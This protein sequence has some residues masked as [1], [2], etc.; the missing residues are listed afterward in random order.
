MLGATQAAL[1][2]ARAPSALRTAMVSMPFVSTLRPSIQLGLLKGIGEQHGFAVDTFHLSLELAAQ[3]GL[4]TYETLCHH[5]G[6]MF[7]DWLFSVEAFG[8][9][10]PDLA[11]ELP[12]VF[13]RELGELERAALLQA[14]GFERLRREAVP[15]FLRSVSENIDWTRYDVIGFTSTFQQTVASAA[16]ARRIRAVHPGVKIVFGGANLDGDMGREVVRT[17]PVIDYG[18]SGEAD[19]TFPALLRAFAAGREPGPL[20]GLI[21]RR[22]G[23]VLSAPVGPPTT[24]M[25]ELPAPIYDEYFERAARLDL[26]PRGGARQVSLPIETSRGC[27][28]GAKSHCT[29]CG[30]NGATMQ[31]RSKSSARVRSE[32]ASLSRRY[33][34]FRFEAVDNILDHRHIKE[35]LPELA[36]NDTS[37]TLFYEIK[38][39][40]GREQVKLMREAGI[41][42]VQPGIES[43]SSPILR[44]MRKGVKAAQNVNLLRWARYY[45]VD[46][47]WNVIFGFPGERLEDH[48]A[49]AELM[50]QI[51]HLAPPTGAGPLWMERFSPLFRERDNFPTT[52]LEPEA[53]YRYVYPAG[54]N[55]DEIAYFFDYELEGALP[56][57]DLAFLGQAAEHWRALWK[58]ESK[59]RLTFFKSDDFLQVDDQR[60]PGR[61]R[62]HTFE[63][64]LARLY[65]AASDRPVTILSLSRSL[66]LGCSDRAIAEALTEFCRRGLMM[67]DEGSYLA[68]AL[69]SRGEA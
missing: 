68:L 49:Q 39:N 51:V 41:R 24:A 26:L 63:G 12:R 53:S 30:L 14:G 28:W 69:P 57:D 7:G 52:R 3:L 67:E 44:L 36:A 4:Q 9:Q 33:R 31:Y 20:P 60:E 29:F 50:A 13:E 65:H 34:T 43:L 59:P 18:V 22:Q 38:A 47:S 16:L 23:E 1:A 66:E 8:D 45:G 15:E 11:A 46:V 40:A 62:T 17:F 10:A 64:P 56:Q 58:S 25:D 37:Y 55:L 27:W 42:H 6:P 35:L 32:L 21:S 54:T 48:R 19:S 2:E 61:T 5:R